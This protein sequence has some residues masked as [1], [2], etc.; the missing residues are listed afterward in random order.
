MC[1]HQGQYVVVVVSD[2]L[3]Q[4]MA[5]NLPLKKIR[6]NLSRSFSNFDVALIRTQR[7]VGYLPI[8]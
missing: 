4:I 2:G 3:Y 1:I 6:T 5:Q 8:C 7:F